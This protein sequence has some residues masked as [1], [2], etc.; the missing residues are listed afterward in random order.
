MIEAAR[1]GLQKMMDAE[2]RRTDKEEKA[3]AAEACGGW[4]RLN[5]DRGTA[6]KLALVAVL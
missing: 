2:R 6:E 5:C 4:I 3:A 1:M